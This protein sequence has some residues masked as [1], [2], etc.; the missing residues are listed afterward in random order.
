MSGLGDLH[1]PLLGQAPAHLK[2]SVRRPKGYILVTGPVGV[3]D[4][5][6]TL[7][8]VHCGMHWKVEPSSGKQRG[9]CMNC[10]GPTCGKRPCETKCVPAERMIE[11][12][13]GR[14]RLTGALHRLKDK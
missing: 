13:E 8:C 7:Q 9:F 11:E 1:L 3:E 10:N 14:R 5:G 12:M 6:E 4:E 2:H